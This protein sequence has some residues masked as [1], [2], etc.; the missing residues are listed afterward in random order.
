MQRKSAVLELIA[1]EPLE[2]IHAENR[3][4]TLPSDKRLHTEQ[5]QVVEAEIV[6]GYGCHGDLTLVDLHPVRERE[7]VGI[8][9]DVCGVLGGEHRLARLG[10]EHKV[11]TMGVDRGID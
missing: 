7:F 10:I 4:L 5:R 8:D 1:V 2:K 6:D 9:A 3:S 11:N